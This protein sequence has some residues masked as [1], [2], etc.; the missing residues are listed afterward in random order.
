MSDFP[1]NPVSTLG[2]ARVLLSQQLTASTTEAALPAIT[3]PTAGGDAA[4]LGTAPQHVEKIVL[5]ADP[6]NST[7]NVLIGLAG[8]ESIVLT[9]GTIIQLELRDPTQ[10]S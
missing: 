10:L 2:N 1:T 5:Q 3:Q 6:A 7:N 9:V 8:N 4:T